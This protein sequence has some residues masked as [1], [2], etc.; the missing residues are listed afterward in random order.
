MQYLKHHLLLFT[1]LLTGC[2]MDALKNE[3]T[4]VPTSFTTMDDLFIPDPPFPFQVP[5]EDYKFRPVVHRQNYTKDNKYEKNTYLYIKPYISSKIKQLDDVATFWQ[6]RVNR[7]SNSLIKIQKKGPVRIAGTNAYEL[8]YIVIGYDDDR[9]KGSL[10][11]ERVYFIPVDDNQ[12]AAIRLVRDIKDDNQITEFWGDWTRFLNS[13]KIGTPST[14]SSTATG[15]TPNTR[16]YFVRNMNFDIPLGDENTL[17]LWYNDQNANRTDSWNTKTGKIR[18]TYHIADGYDDTQKSQNDL[19]KERAEGWGSQGAEILA[20]MFSKTSVDFEYHEVPFGLD[21]TIYG[22]SAIEKITT[23]MS[24]NVSYKHGKSISID[25]HG[26][27]K[28]IADNKE[29]I[30]EWLGQFRVIK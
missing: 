8:I 23:N 2:A 13:I 24:F 25:F 1:L 27:S 21:D 4:F 14:Q 29:F 30:L 16:H 19:F 12:V 3:I 5:F 26:D 28:T 9:E 17:N 6:T 7:E 20:A 11:I 15:K 18:V 22:H 10:F